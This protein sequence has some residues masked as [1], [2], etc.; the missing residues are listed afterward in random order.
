MS[1]FALLRSHDDLAVACRERITLLLHRRLGLLFAQGIGSG[2]EQ[3]RKR[4]YDER[5]LSNRDM[6]QIVL[7]CAFTIDSKKQVLHSR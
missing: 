4:E 1:P 7:I 6:M 5:G 3:L 2:S